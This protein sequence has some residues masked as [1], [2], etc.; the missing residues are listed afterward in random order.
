MALPDRATGT[1]TALADSP[2]S[3]KAM[4]AVP[5][6]SLAKE[7][8]VAKVT[9]GVGSSSRIVT[10]RAAGTP[11]VAPLAVSRVSVI[12]SSPSKIASSKIVTVIDAV[13]ASA[14][15]EKVFP[16]CV[17][18]TVASAVPVAATVAV[19]ASPEGL[20][21]VAPSV[22][23]PPPS[24]IEAWTTSSV[25]VGAES[26]SRIVAVWA[27]MEP[28]IAFV[29]APRVSVTVSAFSARRSWS[30]VSVIVAEV[31]PGA[32]ETGL[33]DTV[34]SLPIVAVPETVN[35]TVIERPLAPERDTTTSVAAAPSLIDCVAK[36]KETDGASSSSVIVS[37]LAEIPPETALTTEVIVKSTVSSGSSKRSGFTGT[38]ITVLV[39]PARIVTG[40][41][42]VVK[43]VPGVAVPAIE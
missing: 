25:I 33:T 7:L 3:V 39:V 13:V 4:V 8:A 27:P 12:V 20:E 24:A 6:P 28:G 31:S 17:K 16:D 15:I 34:A 9:V 30:G 11:I 22:K 43:S 5:A 35:G 29:G 19:I 32:K 21:R 41:A 2:E 26:S 37:V 40:L 42:G 36:S 23:E 14:G 1:D 10:V 38:E 18:S